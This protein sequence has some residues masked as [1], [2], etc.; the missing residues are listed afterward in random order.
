MHLIT[1]SGRLHVASKSYT[2]HRRA[3]RRVEEL[4]VASKRP[5]YARRVEEVCTTRRRG[6]HDAS[7]RYA[8]RVEEV[9][10]TRRRATRRVCTTC[11]K[12]TQLSR[13]RKTSRRH[14][15]CEMSNAS[16]R[17]T[18]RQARKTPRRI[19]T[20]SNCEDATNS[21]SDYMALEMTN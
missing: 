11:R 16:K 2:S 21:K 9:C 5:R 18:T 17:Y 4:H 20:L 8:R 15:T 1:W 13:T 7:K 6:M 10:T 3:T 12:D 14:A 19:R